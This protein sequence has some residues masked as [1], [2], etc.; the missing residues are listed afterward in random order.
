M[1]IICLARFARLNE[2]ASAEDRGAVPLEFNRACL[3]YNHIRGRKFAG[4]PP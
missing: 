4:R 3:G 1:R 2:R